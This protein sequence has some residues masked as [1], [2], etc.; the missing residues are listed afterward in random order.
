MTNTKRPPSPG[1][2]YVWC[3]FNNNWVDKS[4]LQSIFEPFFLANN[5][6]ESGFD[7]DKLT[8]DQKQQFQTLIQDLKDKLNNV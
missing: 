4:L 2:N 3:P 1:P 6:T 5:I 8:D 7:Y